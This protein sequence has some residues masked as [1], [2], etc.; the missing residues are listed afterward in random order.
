M[1][2]ADPPSPQSAETEAKL[3]W[4]LSFLKDRYETWKLLNKPRDPL[5]QAI[6]PLL[7]EGEQALADRAG[8]LSF[9]SA[10]L[11]AHVVK[12]RKQSEATG[13][14]RRAGFR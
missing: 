4:A 10:R 7:K 5:V 12:L 2:G 13:K 11:N 9:V 8:G 1:R 6:P 3:R 14:S